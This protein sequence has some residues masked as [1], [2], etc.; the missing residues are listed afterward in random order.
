MSEEKCLSQVQQHPELYSVFFSEQMANPQDSMSTESAAVEMQFVQ[1]VTI[2]LQAPNPPPVNHKRVTTEFK[3][4][5][6]TRRGSNGKDVVYKVYLPS[7]YKGYVIMVE[8]KDTTR[9]GVENLPLG[10]SVSHLCL[11]NYLR[12]HHCLTMSTFTREGQRSQ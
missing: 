5:Y 3:I 9:P 1:S 4:D 7:A 10:S 12:D 8:K 11:E 6:Q 2:P